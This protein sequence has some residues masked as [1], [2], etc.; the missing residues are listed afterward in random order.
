[1]EPAVDKKRA[2]ELAAAWRGKRVAVIGDLILDRY[3]WGKASRISAEAPVPVVA[4]SRTSA[5]PGGAANVLRNVAL[6]GGG[7]SAYGL[8]GADAAGDELAAL[9]EQLGINLSGIVRE[10]VRRT[11]EKTRIIA[12]TQQVVRVDTEDCTELSPAAADALMTRL[13]AELA[14]GCIDAVIIV[15]YAKGAVSRD[16]MQRAAA[17]ARQHGAPVALDPH[18]AHAWGAQGLTVMKPNRAEAFALAGMYFCEGAERIEDDAPLH[19]VAA[20]LRQEWGSD[21]LLISLGAGGMALFGADGELVH[22]PTR[23][24]DVFDVSGA[25]DTVIASYVMALLG[26]ATPAEA[27]VA[28]NHAAGVVVGKVGTA[29]V[30]IEELLASFGEAS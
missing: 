30:D 17:A 4:V 25:G 26:G 16:L 1:M 20:R 23:A 13:E 14:S 6:L 2:E 21:Q 9:L 15:D 10:S 5:A 11:T 27:A 19:E 28:S 7:A 22:V 3:I 24:R 12:G 29:P 8:A 18:P